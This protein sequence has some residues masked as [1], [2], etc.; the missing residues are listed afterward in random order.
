M[1]QA[2]VYGAVM[3]YLKAVAA[4]KTEGRGPGDGLDEGQPRPTTRCS[5]RATIRA[6]G[7]KMHPAYLF[8]VK[9]PSE[10]KGP[11]DYY[12]LA[13]PCRPRRPSGR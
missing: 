12:K 11:W 8:E 1:V 4:T 10:S 3:H 7:R 5:A 13:R 6:D 9:K 2:G